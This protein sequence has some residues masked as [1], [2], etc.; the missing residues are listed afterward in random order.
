MPNIIGYILQRRSVRKYTAQKV[1]HADIDCLLQA[2]MAAPSASNARPWEFVV[3]TDE[4]KLKEMEKC[5]PFGRMGAPLM[6]VVIGNPSIA[7][8]RSS[9]K[10]WVQDCS[11]ATENIL[12]AATGL[13]LGGCWLGVYPIFTLVKRV[14]NVLKLPDE[15]I[16]LCAINLGYPAEEKQPRT[17]YDPSRIHWQ[18]YNS[19]G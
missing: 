12:L 7:A 17:Q 9:E 8:N 19:Q 10:F 16:P 15:T 6:I 13:G 1:E 14:S 5:L 4:N 2:A 11:A 18:E 3:I